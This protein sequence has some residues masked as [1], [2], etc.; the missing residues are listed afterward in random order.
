MYFSYIILLF[1]LFSNKYVF[2]YCRLFDCYENHNQRVHHPKKNKLRGED[3]TKKKNAYK[4]CTSEDCYCHTL[5]ILL[6]I[7]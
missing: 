1:A 7:H 2:V 3:N 6:T 5:N 4:Y